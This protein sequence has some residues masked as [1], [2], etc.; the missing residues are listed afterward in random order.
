MANDKAVIQQALE[1]FEQSQD[2]S[3]FN[4]RTALEDIRFARLAEQW[5]TEVAKLRRDEN[6]PMLTINKLPPFIHSIVNETRQSNPS[7]KVSPVDSGA[8]VDTASVLTGLVRSI[9][10]GSD[11]EVAYDTALEHAVTCGFG[12]FR[13]A[14]DY[15]HEQSFDLEAKIER[16]PNPLMVH[17]DVNSTRFDAM[18]WEYAFVSDF[19]TEDQFK[20]K[21]PGATM[22]SFDG[23]STDSNW[24]HWIKDKEVRVAEYW[25]RT[26]EEKTLLMLSNGAVVLEDR[27]PQVA[28]S[29]LQAGN[30]DVGPVSDDE[31]IRIASLIEGITIANH[32]KTKVNTV[33]RCMI[34][35]AEV[36]E[37][38][39]W[40]GSTIPICPVWGEEVNVDGRRYLRSL[41]RDAI[42]PQQMFNYWRT[43]STEL[44]ALAP[45]APWVGPEGFTEGHEDVWETANSRSHAYMEYAGQVAPQRAQFAGIPAG[46][47]Q[48]SLNAA[49][50]IKSVTSIFNPSLGAEDREK[51]GRAIMARQRESDTANYHFPDNLTRAIRYAGQ[52]L[53]EI[54]PSIYS[55]RQTIRI[56][57]EDDTEKVISLTQQSLEG[58]VPVDEEGKPL[59]YNLA[60]GKYDVTVSSGASFAT[61]RE[62]TREAL[63][64][65]MRQV[66][67]SAQ[68]I[69][70]VLLDHM[71]FEGADKVAERLR[72]LQGMALQGPGAPPAQ[73]GLP[74]ALPG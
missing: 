13:I 42:G 41:V 56:L 31:A 36:L 19:V 47:L 74:P 9:E 49:D 53:V 52:I 33:K 3:D 38:D 37:E 60:V 51:S 23:D 64:E 58:G 57:G 7:I 14:I 39:S 18:D 20:K 32:R 26:E 2:G 69:G 54:I 55:A 72:H 30:Y 35:G 27:L 71:D 43:A 50:D 4:R 8:D 22:V 61:R 59:L 65:I 11:A 5:D 15:A 67:G 62:E 24:R 10:R 66:P 45:K 63:I 34:N 6:R 1:Q 12:F 46:A 40:P 44:V 16:I 17:W 48:E 28:R 73:P 25:Q 68:Y 29:V 70:D 21:Y